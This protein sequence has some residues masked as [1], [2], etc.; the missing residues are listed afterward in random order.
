MIN[1]TDKL[2]LDLARRVS[3]ESYCKRKQV[4]AVLLTEDLIS[5]VGYNGT[6]SGFDNV[7]ELPDGT[8]KAE[9][10]HA[11][12]NA[13]AKAMRAGLSTKGSTLYCTFQCCVHCSKMAYQAGVK[14]V[15]YLEKSNKDG[16]IDFLRLCG[17]MVEQIDY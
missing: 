4:G 7:C 16:G 5:I 13:F 6:A 17:V 12:A 10:L 3:H 14:R 8:T 11:E 1:K 2:Y 15:V 9:V